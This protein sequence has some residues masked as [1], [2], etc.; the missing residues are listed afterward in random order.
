[1]RILV[2]L[3]GGVDSAVAAYLLKQQGF[4]VVGGFMKNYVSDSGTCTT[5]DDSQEAIKVADFLGIELLSFDMQQE[6]NDRI[7]QYIYDGYSKGITPNP[8]VLCNSLIKFDVF[9]ERA[10]A[11]GFDKIAMG[12]YARIVED[13][14]QYKLFRGIDYNKDQ[15]YFLAGLNQYQLSKSLFPLGNLTKPEIRKIA[16]EIGLPNA[17]RPDSQG[18]CFIGNVPIKQF[19]EQK[20]PKKTGNI[21][22][23]DGTI[24]GQH[25][26]S[27]FYTVGQRHGLGLNFKCYVVKTDVITNTVVVGE[28][29]HEELSHTSLIALDWHW[30]GEKYDLPLQVKTKIRYRQEPQ[31]AMLVSFENN[32]INISFD[33]QQWA[34]AS[35]QV[36]VAYIGDECIGSGIIR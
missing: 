1:M 4:D 23:S 12:H 15:S 25:E 33:E 34:I 35:G 6:Y 32:K 28:K 20:L 9:L 27:W 10:L 24:V 30:I 11:L 2:G 18:L 22:L 19:L 17:D 8:D 26:G 7:I 5:Y 16:Q 29:S 14:G 13:G 36:V 3:S 31:P 21:V